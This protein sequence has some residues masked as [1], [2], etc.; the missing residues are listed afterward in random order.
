VSAND[1]VVSCSSA[2]L[3]LISAAVRGGILAPGPPAAD[4]ATTASDDKTMTLP[5]SPLRAFTP[6]SQLSS[7][8]MY[9]LL[10]A[11]ESP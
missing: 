10:I 2:L 9:R 7:Q 8:L 5:Q 1:W 6:L 4:R 11:Q 3:L